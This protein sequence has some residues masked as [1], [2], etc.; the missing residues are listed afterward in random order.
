[1]LAHAID[2]VIWGQFQEDK[3]MTADQAGFSDVD[4]PAL[5]LNTLQQCWIF[6]PAGEI[7]LWSYGGKWR[8]RHLSTEW[9]QPYLNSHDYIQEEQLLWG[10]HAKQKEGFTLLRDGSQGLKHAIT[11]TKGIIFDP[12]N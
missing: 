8:S 3:L 7:F 10:T 4:L 11:T 2:G 6:G 12:Q 1:M 5:R 9:E